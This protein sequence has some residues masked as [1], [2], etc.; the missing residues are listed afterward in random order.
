MR[1][2]IVSIV[3][4]ALMVAPGPAVASQQSAP[5]VDEAKLFATMAAAIPLGSR[6]KLATSAGRRMTDTLMNVTADAIVVKRDTRTPEA[7]Q[8]IAFAELAQLQLDQ[9]RGGMSVGKAIGIGPAAGAGAI[10]TL[11]AFALQLD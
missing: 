5:R 2:V 6:I 7:A 11:I 10:L 4:A 3:V 1:T 8:T 9:N